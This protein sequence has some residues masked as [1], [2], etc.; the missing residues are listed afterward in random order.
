MFKLTRY[1]KN[2][3]LAPIG[4]DWE[5]KAVFNPGV[6]FKDG[7]VYLLYRALGEFDDQISRL[8]L[9]VSNDGMTFQRVGNG[10]VFGPG[11]EYDQWSTE[12]PR[13]VELEGKIYLT[14]VAVPQ[15]IPHRSRPLITSG[16]LASTVDF[17]S[18]TRHG[19]I[20][21][22]NSDNKDVVLFP[23]K[24]NGRYA[25]LHRPHLWT[26]P[27]EKPGI[28][29]AYSDDLVTWD[30]HQIV[31]ECT[32]KDDAKIGAGSPPIKTAV[33]W[34]LIYHHV[35]ESSE[36]EIY[37]AKIMLLDLNNPALVKAALPYPVLE[38]ETSYEKEGWVKNVTF[39]SGAFIRDGVLNVY[40]GAGDTCC[41][42]ATGSLNELLTAL[43]ADKKVFLYNLPL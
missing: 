15:K 28:W 35:R 39:P 43:A 38:P 36:G 24:I 6:I 20:T 10:P 4:N 29:L 12:D 8:G 31:Y 11:A 27:L 23:E 33:G 9:A 18:F 2:P 1:R 30:S 41:A 40:Y 42:L 37:S 34:I 26:K 3:V 17:K 32:H 7:K 25:M 14:Y 13:L 5:S 16:A 21:P 22:L 19:V